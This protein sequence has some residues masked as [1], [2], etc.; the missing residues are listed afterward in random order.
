[1]TGRRQSA[2]FPLVIAP[3][4]PCESLRAPLTP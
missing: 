3:Y 4:V 1:M 2:Q